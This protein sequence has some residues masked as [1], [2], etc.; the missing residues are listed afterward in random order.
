MTSED[1]ADAN[2]TVLPRL[3]MVERVRAEKFKIDP[4]LELP[5]EAVRVFANLFQGSTQQAERNKAYDLL[6]QICGRKMRL[7][8]SCTSLGNLRPEIS[9]RTRPGGQSFLM[10]KMPP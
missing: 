1:I 5:N 9:C 10:A 6:G 4:A 2:R 3:W 7:A 8:C